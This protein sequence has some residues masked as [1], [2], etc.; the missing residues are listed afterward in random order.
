NARFVHGQFPNAAVAPHDVTIAFAVLHWM[1][2]Y[3]PGAPTWCD[4]LGHFANVTRECIFVEFVDPR[5]ATF[6]RN[7]DCPLRPDYDKD[8]FISGLESHF[9]HVTELGNTSPTRVIYSARIPG[10]R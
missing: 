7:L 1:Y 10:E 6:R 4:L 5:D 3:L 9:V 8:A 2:H